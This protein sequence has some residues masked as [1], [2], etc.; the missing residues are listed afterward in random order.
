M[1][2]RT[3]LITSLY[4]E[5]VRAVGGEVKFTE[6]MEAIRPQIADLISR[7]PRDIDNEARREIRAV[8]TPTRAKRATNLKR[9]LDQLLAGFDEDED[10]AYVDPLLDQAHGLGRADGVDKTLRMW[11]VEDLRHLIESRY[12]GAAEVTAAAVDFAKTS[13]EVID[14][15][16]TVGANFIGDGNWPT[17][18][19][20]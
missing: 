15:M 10:E 3:E 20:S 7:D 16:Q 8:I 6:A 4:D 12:G 13:F 11:T 19:K 5:H 14:R 17:G 1:I 9:S 18:A 2:D